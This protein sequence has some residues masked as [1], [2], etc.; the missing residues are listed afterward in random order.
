MPPEVALPN[1]SGKTAFPALC[2]EG[3]KVG[4]ALYL[5]ESEARLHHARGLLRLFKFEQAGQLKFLKR[6]I[7]VSREVELSW[8]LN[9]R[10]YADDLLDRAVLAA[11]NDEP[12]NIRDELAFGIAAEH[13]RQYA[14]EELDKLQ[15]QLEALYPAYRQVKELMNKVKP[16]AGISCADLKRQL[17]FLFRSH[18]L[19]SPAVFDSYSRYLRGAKLRAERISSGPARDEAK[20]ET[21]EAYLDR[22][23]IAAESVSEI[24]EKPELEAFWLLTEECRLAVFAPEVTP[25]VRGPLKK[26]EPAWQEL[27]F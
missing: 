4:Q 22:F 9:Y 5:K 24:T 18:F 10:D 27:R 8:F 7:R 6:T 2:D 20:L 15:K 12:W 25:A 14:G 16:R 3:D 23:Y 13:A 21:I 1:A 11:F 19:R 26:L 17:G